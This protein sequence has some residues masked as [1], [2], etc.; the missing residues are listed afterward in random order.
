MLAMIF[1]WSMTLPAKAETPWTDWQNV[2]S[3]ASNLTGKIWSVDDKI[4]ITAVNLADR[5][6]GTKYVLLGEIHD[7]VDHHLLQAWLVNAIGEKNPAYASVVMEM[8]SS[9]SAKVLDEYL[10]KN[11]K[12]AAGLG[13]ALNWAESGWPKW[14]YYQPIA[15]AAFGH[16]MPIIAGDPAKAI[17]RQIARDGFGL[18]NVNEQKMLGLD[19]EFANELNKALNHNIKSSHCDLLPA[20]MIGPMVKIQRYRD[21]KL[22]RAMVDAA[23]EKSDKNYV[24]N[25]ILIA[26]N[27]H[28]RTD[29][30][31]PWY[32]SHQDPDGTYSSVVMMEADDDDSM[33]DLIFTNPQGQAAGHFFWFTPPAKREDQCEK[34]RKRFEK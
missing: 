7:N 24:G 34:L 33:E 27:G 4:F 32:L 8:I 14:R 15:E 10:S 3:D 16:N 25:I 1:V 2:P 21:A 6:A 29:R 9:D 17:I 22:A 28:V 11:D 19:T 31:V 13:S 20:S 18:I 12:D 23:G 30:G 26:G 5:L